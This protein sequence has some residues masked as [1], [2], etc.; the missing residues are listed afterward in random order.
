MIPPLCIECNS[1]PSA[2]HVDSP[3]LAGSMSRGCFFR[4]TKYKEQLSA[5]SEEWL[6]R[7]VFAAN[8]QTRGFVSKLVPPIET[9]SGVS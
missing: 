7:C 2:L 5:H 6:T 9:L 4:L 3:V 1:Y 8:P